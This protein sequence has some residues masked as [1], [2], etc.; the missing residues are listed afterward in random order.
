MWR[1]FRSLLL[2]ASSVVAIGACGDGGAGPGPSDNFNVDQCR[3]GQTMADPTN[4]VSPA[5]VDVISLTS[6]L[7]GQTLQATFH[8]RDL[9]L[10]LTFNRTGVPEAYQEYQWALYV[11]ADNNRQTG[12]AT[13]WDRGAEYVMAARHFVVGT[14]D[15]PASPFVDRIEFAVQT[16]VAK[17]EGPG[18]GPVY[19][20]DRIILPPIVS[21]DTLSDT[22]T[23]TGDIP[24]ITPQ[25]RL[26]FETFDYNPGGT[27]QMDVS[28]CGSTGS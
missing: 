25:S 11:D 10:R 14:P 1:S 22:I 8:L 6:A 3:P 9:P 26:F 23:L 2:V 4:D 17:Y 20:P 15:M 28:S 19:G 16:D 18:W 21:V 24:G 12:A 13:K 5:H 7:D 27:P